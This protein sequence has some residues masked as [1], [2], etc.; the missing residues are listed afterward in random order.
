MIQYDLPLTTNVGTD[1]SPFAVPLAGKKPHVLFINSV[2]FGR[3][4]AELIQIADMTWTN[5]TFD[6]HWDLNK[7]GFGD[8]YDKRGDID[9]NTVIVQ[10]LEEMLTSHRH[11]DVIVIPAINGWNEFSLKTRQAILYRVEEGA[12]LVLVHPMP[13]EK[14][15]NGDGENAAELS[16]LSPLIAA[17][18]EKPYSEEWFDRMFCKPWQA[19]EH[20]ITKGIAFN[21]LPYDILACSP[22]RADGD[23]IVSTAAGEPVAA[24]RQMKKGRVVAFAYYSR[25]ILPQHKDYRGLD[26]CFNPIV[27][28]W[29]GAVLPTEFNFME[30]FHRLIARSIYWSAGA[31]NAS[32]IEKAEY[33]DGSIRVKTWGTG[34]LQVSVRNLYGEC[35]CP[36]RE[37]E[38]EFGLPEVCS[39]G[40]TFRVEI[41]LMDEGAVCDFYTLVVKLPPLVSFE[42]IA[43][44]NAV[45]QNGDT[46]TAEIVTHGEDCTLTAGLVDDYGRLLEEQR[47]ESTGGKSS[48][49]FLLKDILSIHVHVAVRA[50]IAGKE[51]GRG[52]SSDCVVTPSTRCLSDFEVFMNPQNRGQGDLLHYINKLFPEI[53]MTGNFIGDNRLT[54]M[55]G[56]HGL[57]VYWYNRAPYVKNKEQYLRTRDKAFLIRKPCLNDERFWEENKKNIEKNVGANRKYGPIAYFAQD[58]GSLTCYNDEFDFCFCGHCMEKMRAWLKTQYP[59]LDALNAEWETSYADWAEAV[60]MTKQEAKSSGVWT[61]WADHRRFMELTYTDAYRHMRDLIQSSDPEGRVRMSGCQASTAYTGN[62]YDLLHQYVRYFEAYPSGSQYEF[63]RSFKHPDTILGGWFGYG[64]DGAGVRHNIWYALLHGLTL[65]SIFWEYSCLNPDFTFSRSALDMGKAFTEIRR[66]GIGKLLLYASKADTLGVAVHYSM[67]SVHGTNING[68]KVFF[69]ENRGAWLELLEDL[70]VQYR[71]VSSRQIEEGELSNGV[72]LLILPYSVAIGGRESLKIEEFA[73]AGGIVLGDAQT[74]IMDGHCK[75]QNNGALDRLFGIERLNTDHEEYF[76]N[77]EY[78]PNREFTYFD[79]SP[80]SSEAG[81][82][83]TAAEPAIR[84]TTGIRGFCDTFS[85][86]I[87]S[88]VVNAFGKGYGI[89]L[90]FAARE[91]TQQRKNGS[92][93]GLRH[94]LSEILSFAKVVRP[95]SVLDKSGKKLQSGIES[96]YYTAAGA[97]AVCLLKRLGHAQVKYDGLSKNQASGELSSEEIT[98]VFPK[99]THIYDVRKKKYLG[100]RQEIHDEITDGDVNIY[101]LVPYRAKD[102]ILQSTGTAG[103]ADVKAILEVEGGMPE[104]TVFAVNIHEPD[105]KYSFLYSKN[106]ITKG[107]ELCFV[108]PFA[109]NDAAGNWRVRVKDVLTGVESEM[110]ICR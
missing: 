76:I 4:L 22:Y 20:F 24:V 28:T 38:T 92:G 9:N 89:Y 64:A 86:N 95:A 10:N 55:S 109:R 40:G 52:R 85:G 78:V 58:E 81:P 88:L 100:F 101:A 110:V 99:Q 7:W 60:P 61:S 98:A 50:E 16:L 54:A 93:E 74:G 8:F 90:N 14:P 65:I 63:H 13:G 36:V 47:M 70:G 15:G 17:G 43:L 73:R 31:E 2:K 69:E 77:A 26:G 11:F 19:Q 49:S 33:Q 72:K 30:I 6:R 1:Y 71:F 105:G 44:S 80:V 23:V 41:T 25:D 32:Q 39:L 62:D 106:Y 35:V 59:S 66:E 67:A 42:S 21:L 27:D 29:R 34:R 45:L 94:I 108:I 68:R 82:E 57:G 102:L 5:V 75:M 97:Q 51:A 84:T 91:Y 48:F 103:K 87:A 53:G 12:G 46:L 56:S 107:N 37:V 18:G 104:S 79:L 83:V 96:F 3:E